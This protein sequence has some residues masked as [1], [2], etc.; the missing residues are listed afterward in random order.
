MKTSRPA[1]NE[2]A[3][4]RDPKDARNQ[5]RRIRFD[6][7]VGMTFSNLV[8]FFIMLAAAVTLHAHG[9]TTVETSTQAAEALRPLAGRFTFLVFALG[10]IGTGMLAV[11]V[12]AGSAAYAVGEACKW[13]CGLARKPLDAKGFYGILAA[14][15]LLGLTINFP[16]V[17]KMTHLSPIR[18]LFWSA[19]INGVTAIPIMIVT[20]LMFQNKKVMGQF[21]RVSRRL[22]L[23]GWLATIAMTLA[24]IGMFMSWKHS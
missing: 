2:E 21:T 7:Y 6:T 9:V 5:F 8:A 4:L 18:A 13:P 22:R 11:P 19:V 12:L 24:A 15:T 3:L 16:A 1:P 14:A 23:M 17:Q 20:M 10:I